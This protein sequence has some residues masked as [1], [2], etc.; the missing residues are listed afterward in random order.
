MVIFN[1]LRINDGKD[2]LFVECSVDNL[3]IY[4]KMYIKE[5]YL[6]HYSNADTIGE[7]RDLSKVI[8]LFNNTVDDTTIT[9]FRACVTPSDIPIGDY[10]F[11][12]F[13]KG[14]FFVKVICD[15]EL[16]ASTSQFACGTDDTVD[17]GVIVDWKAMYTYGMQFVAELNRKDESCNPH[18]NFIQ[19]ILTWFSIK[20]AIS[21]CDF[22]QLYKLWDRFIRLYAHSSRITNGMGGCG[23][24]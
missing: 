20:L 9:T 2:K 1:E 5:V 10:G 7:P 16:P 18:D 23:C 22:D 19:F 21:S 15:G 24:K 17:I 8:Q 14:L 11:T 3:S 4:D 12:T 6:Y 13:D